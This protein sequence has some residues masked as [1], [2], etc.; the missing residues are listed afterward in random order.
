MQNVP[1]LSVRF[2]LALGDEVVVDVLVDEVV[3]LRRVVPGAGFRV[4]G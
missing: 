4:Q 1:T 3:L 2:D